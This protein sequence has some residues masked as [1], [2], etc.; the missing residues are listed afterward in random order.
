MPI[1]LILLIAPFLLF[2]IVYSCAQIF[3]AWYIYTQVKLPPPRQASS[4]LT[5]DVFIPVYDEEYTLVEASLM[6]A[7]AITYPHQTFLL[8][9]ARYHNLIRA[10]YERI[11][12]EVG[13]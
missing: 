3:A 8:D 7:K 1:L 6:A 11:A 5:V 13:A 12:N 10:Y 2:S 4:G 9:D